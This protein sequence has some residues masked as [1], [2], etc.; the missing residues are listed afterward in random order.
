MKNIL[1]LL[2]IATLVIIL[3]PIIEY[4]FANEKKL[5]TPDSQQV[6]IDQLKEQN[7]L[8]KEALNE[9]GATTK[10]EAVRIYAQGVKQRSGALQY[11]VMCKKLKDK[12]EKDLN[13]A[14]NYAWVT[15]YS[16]P[17]VTKYDIV[18]TKEINKDKYLIT[19]EFILNDST[20]VFGKNMT[21]LEAQKQNGFWCISNINEK[22]IES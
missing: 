2:L 6:Y 17:W 16:S 14:K 19:I 4:S 9:F 15:G 5:C 3:T 18:K 13:E 20:G 12:F 11:S 8:L 7:K 10:E 22:F 1:R 21:D